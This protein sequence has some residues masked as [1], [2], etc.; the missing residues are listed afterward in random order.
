MFILRGLRRW[1][2]G[3]HPRNVG[4]TDWQNYSSSN[5]SYQGDE[6]GRKQAFIAEFSR[7]AAARC[8]WDLGCNT[9]LYSEIMIENGAERVIGFDFDTLALEAAVAR[10]T[11]KNL[12]MLPLLSD[13]ANPSPAQGWAQAERMGLSSRIEADAVVALALVHHLAIGRNIPLASV[14]DWLL[15]LAPAGVVEFV[16]K[17]D[18]MVKRMLQF[19]EDVFAEYGKAQFEAALRSRAEI[20]RTLE[21]ASEGRILYQYRRRP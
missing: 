7:A 9:G 2:D 3:L 12:A 16:P 10:A 1:I 18:P 20:V 4:P 6:E 5:E 21:L 8:V 11:D 14:L 19:R 17:S 13:T 15:S